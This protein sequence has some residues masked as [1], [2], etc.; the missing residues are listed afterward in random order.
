MMT[1]LLWLAC[2]TAPAPAP[3]ATPTTPPPPA[4]PGAGGPP[5]PG[6][7]VPKIGSAAM[8][9]VALVAVE[10]TAMPAGAIPG[11]DAG[12][13]A[14]VGFVQVPA[15]PV[16]GDGSGDPAL[17]A[18]RALLALGPPPAPWHNAA[19]GSSLKVDRAAPDAD[20]RLFVE[21]SGEIRLAGTCAAPY[22]RAQ[23]EQTLARS[24]PQFEIRLN[25]SAS[26]WRCVGDIRGRCE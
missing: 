3:P 22:L 23:V 19:D 12:C 11:G 13:G 9:P 20:G 21:I 6:A 14:K 15:P 4:P 1:L 17:D 26:E 25:G 8:V 7:A 10:G 24:H 2:S 16:V 18:L 5:A